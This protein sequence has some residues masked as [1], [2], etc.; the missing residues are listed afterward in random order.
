[1]EDIDHDIV[2]SKASGVMDL[3]SQFWNKATAVRIN[4]GWTRLQN[5]S[6]A[7]A[8]ANKSAQIIDERKNKR[9]GSQIKIECMVWQLKSTV[10]AGARAKASAPQPVSLMTSDPN[11]TDRPLR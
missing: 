8:T 10:N 6:L 11:Q 4:P 3:A 5:E 1:M 9:E 2:S 7:K